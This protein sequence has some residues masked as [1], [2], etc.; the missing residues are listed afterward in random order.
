MKRFVNL[1]VPAQSPRIVIKPATTER[2]EPKRATPLTLIGTSVVKQNTS[3]KTMPPKT[4]N[5]AEAG[6]T[7][8]NNGQ[9]DMI[10]RRLDIYV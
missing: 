4:A 9:H 5:P 2:A 6:Y 8:L 3:L 10:G 1:P 7:S